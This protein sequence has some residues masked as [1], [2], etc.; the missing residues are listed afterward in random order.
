[1][2][3]ATFLFFKKPKSLRKKVEYSEKQNV[4]YALRQ[5]DN[6]SS[7]IQNFY[8]INWK[9][10]LV[11]ILQKFPQILVTLFPVTCVGSKIS[12]FSTSPD[13]VRSKKCLLV[14]KRNHC[15]L[16]TRMY[17]CGIPVKELV[18]VSWTLLWRIMG[19]LFLAPLIFS[20]GELRD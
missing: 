5:F 20:P 4:N 14:K 15:F 10:Q 13:P 16:R 19:N 3:S 1:M 7:S 18:S 12:E 17:V 9:P 2:F 8:L 11:F 6:F